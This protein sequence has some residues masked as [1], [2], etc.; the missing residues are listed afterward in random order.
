MTFSPLCR[1]HKSN[2]LAEQYIAE[3][4]VGPT[5]LDDC[6]HIALATLAKADV[7]V[8]WNFRH[9]VN[10]SRIKGYNGINMKLGYSQ[11]EIRT[12]YEVSNDDV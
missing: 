7:L 4:V 12:P 6:K 3:N 5:S 1:N 2:G 9:I 8:S 10:V 11:I